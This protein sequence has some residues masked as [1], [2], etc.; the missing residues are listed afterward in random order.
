VEG[1][2]VYV[3]TGD[4][5]VLHQFDTRT[6]KEM[7]SLAVAFGLTDTDDAMGEIDAG[8]PVAIV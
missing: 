6:L 5:G 3:T 1:S 2:S 7:K 4:D 8:A